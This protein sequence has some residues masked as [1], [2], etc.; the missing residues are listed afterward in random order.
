MVG[1]APQSLFQA[2][3]QRRDLALVLQHLTVNGAFRIFLHSPSSVSISTVR[4]ATSLCDA[5][6]GM[7]CQV[8]SFFS[9]QWGESRRRRR[10][11]AYERGSTGT[12]PGRAMNETDS[13]EVG[14]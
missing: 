2:V 9:R 3:L 14:E 1:G 4:Y 8:Q 7:V 11:R 13:T 12:V 5:Y 10:R 6:R